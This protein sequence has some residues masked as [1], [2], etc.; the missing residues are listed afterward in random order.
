MAS[1]TLTQVLLL[2]RDVISVYSGLLAFLKH[3]TPDLVYVALPEALWP[4]KDTTLG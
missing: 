1:Y 4:T 2:L 3:I